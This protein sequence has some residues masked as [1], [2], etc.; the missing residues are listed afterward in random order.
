M[1]TKACNEFEKVVKDL[2]LDEIVERLQIIEE[3]AKVMLA[4]E[5]SCKKHV[6]EEVDETELEKELDEIEAYI[7][8]ARVFKKK[9]EKLTLEQTSKYNPVLDDPSPVS[10]IQDEVILG[11]PTTWKKRGRQSDRVK[12]LP[13]ATD[14]FAASQV[15][16]KCIFCSLPHPSADCLKARKMKLKEREER[17]QQSRCC[18]LC[19]KPNHTVNKCFMKTSCLCCGKKHNIL[20]CRSMQ[21]KPELTEKNSASENKP[22][23]VSA[24]KDQFLASFCSKPS[25]AL[26]T[27]KVVIRG[28]GKRRTARAIIDSGSQRSYL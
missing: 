17:V 1:F 15:P 12:E 11:L 13:S 7:D 14:L 5:E 9:L 8:R 10:E 2:E 24:E 23:V 20:L 22:V 19:L 6:F 21:W 18:F 27:L 25:V 16:K 3:K 28:N 26:Q 4:C